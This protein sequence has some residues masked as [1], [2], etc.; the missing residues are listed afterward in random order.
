M[1]DSLKFKETV[2][3]YD[4]SYGTGISAYA[5]DRISIQWNEYG[6][7][8]PVFMN[9]AGTETAGSD[10]PL[11][12][13]DPMMDES[14]NETEVG[15]ELFGQL[16][17][18][19][20]HTRL[21]YYKD[22]YAGYVEEG[23]YRAQAS[24]GGLGTWILKELFEK[25]LI[26]G[27]IHVKENNDPNN[28]ALFH[29]DI[30]RSIEEINQGA[31][32]KYYPVE[33]SQVLQKIK[34]TPGRYAI[35]GLPA[36]IFSVRLLARQDP[37]INERIKYAIGLIC[38]HLKSAR[39]ADSIGWQLGF[40]PGDIKKIDFRKKLDHRPAHRYGVQ[41]TGVINGETKTIIKPMKEIVGD[42][43]GQGFFK[44][45]ASDYTDDVMNETADMT[46]GDAWLPEYTGESK[47]TN[48][49]LV[50]HPEIAQIIKDGIADQKLRLDEIDSTKMIA[51]QAS[52]FRHTQDELGY[53]L[54]MRDKDSDWRPKKRIEASNKLPYIRKKIQDQREKLAKESHIHFKKAVDK[55]DLT[56]F[57]D[58]M[59][60]LVK[61][62]EQYYS[63]AY[64]MNQGIGTLAKKIARKI[65]S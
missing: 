4:Y 51:S 42:N 55:D 43:W 5:D 32:T 62:Y 17:D 52:H 12:L 36:Y 21:G 35:I 2:L 33:M 18:V 65:K 25:D 37:V 28:P 41:V 10:I 44:V 30:S 13:I 34:E 48:V 19:K 59:A 22:L 26:D 50:R 38:G 54:W 47:G 31:K 57:T 29:Y 45:K 3:K 61:K 64:Y 60:P 1:D 6:E 15:K 24:S 23:N 9:E 58:Q 14:L 39:F 53:R 27:V 16:P 11:S 8:K 49:L 63:Y 20:F 7:Y 46:I 56:Y 40:K